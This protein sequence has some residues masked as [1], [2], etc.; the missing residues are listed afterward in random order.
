DA[1][2]R[3]AHGELPYV[4]YVYWYGPLAPALLGLAAK[5]GGAGVVPFV[6][7]GLAVAFLILAATYALARTFVGPLGAFLAT[8]LVAPLAFPLHRLLW[9]NLWPRHFL[10]A[11][12]S[13]I[14]HARSPM[15]ASSL[16]SL[17]GKVA[18][19]AAGAA[20]LLAAGRLLS[21]R[22]PVP[23]PLGAAALGCVLALA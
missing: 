22:K 20:V 8:A 4:D 3:F 9:E 13:T 6:G 2:T 10:A 11:A 12:G 14:L 15:T 18:L 23:L 16:V 21:Q 19:Y 5:L 1:G 17:G 7:L